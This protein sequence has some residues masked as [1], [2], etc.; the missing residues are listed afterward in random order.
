MTVYYKTSVFIFKNIE[1]IFFN[2][3]ELIEVFEIAE[4]I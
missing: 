1:N 2:L 4:S 3:K